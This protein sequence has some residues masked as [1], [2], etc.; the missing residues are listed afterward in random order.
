R[1]ASDRGEALPVDVLMKLAASTDQHIKRLA[2]ENLGQSA[3][4]PD[5]PRLEAMISKTPVGPAKA[6]AKDREKKQAAERKALDDEI[7]LTVKKIRF[8]KDLSLAKGAEAWRE[9]IR[10]ASL[11]PALAEFA[12]RHDCE[13]TTAGCSP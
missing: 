13:L 10:K 11:D 8:R 6:T 4:L 3:D 5:I 9:V 12:W 2:V 1:V 7:K